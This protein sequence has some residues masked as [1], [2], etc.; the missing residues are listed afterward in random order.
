MKSAKHC[1]AANMFS[2]AFSGSSA[3][4]ILLWANSINS[5]PTKASKSESS[6]L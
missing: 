6:P 5:D 4:L 1:K 3:P 2:L